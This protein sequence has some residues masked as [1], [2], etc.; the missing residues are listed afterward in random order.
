M[1]LKPLKFQSWYLHILERKKVL[2]SLGSM[3]H[4]DKH[5][6]LLIINSFLYADHKVQI[7]N[8]FLMDLKRLAHLSLGYK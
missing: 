6:K 1:S 2:Q 7:S 4:N 8:L 5:K 3:F